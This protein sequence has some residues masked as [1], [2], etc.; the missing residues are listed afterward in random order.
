MNKCPRCN[1]PQEGIYRCQYCGYVLSKH[2]IKH[3]K[4]IRQKLEDLLD[5]LNKRP[6]HFK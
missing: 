6:D 1:L 3:T 2:R 4:T 5:V